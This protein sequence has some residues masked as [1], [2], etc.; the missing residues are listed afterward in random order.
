MQAEEDVSGR[1]TT[2]VILFFGLVVATLWNQHSAGLMKAGV[3]Y[4][5]SRR[6]W[7]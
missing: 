5:V 6:R 4:P 7:R 2:S 3:H 1:H